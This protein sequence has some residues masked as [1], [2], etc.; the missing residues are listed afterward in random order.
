[1]STFE[2]MEAVRGLLKR[3]T[4]T[5]TRYLKGKLKLDDIT[6]NNAISGLTRLGH[7]ERDHAVD[8][9]T[10]K[11]GNGDQ[12]TAMRLVLLRLSEEGQSAKVP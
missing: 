3:T 8:W 9:G 2:N 6:V 1:M 11:T 4:W 10:K 12:P 7:L 5:T